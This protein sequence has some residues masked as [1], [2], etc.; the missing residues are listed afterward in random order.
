MPGPTSRG[1]YVGRSKAA[2][3]AA[4]AQRRAERIALD[5]PRCAVCGRSMVAG[6]ERPRPLGNDG[7]HYLCRPP[8]A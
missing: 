6:Q 4:V 3:V 7:A 5:S 8:A 1:N 2:T